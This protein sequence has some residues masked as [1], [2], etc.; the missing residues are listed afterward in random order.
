MRGVICR[1][2]ICD[3][4][5]AVS[6]ESYME[7]LAITQ[8][9]PEAT[10]KL[11]DITD[12]YIE[13]N[14]F[15][16]GFNLMIKKSTGDDVDISYITSAKGK[17]HC[18][19]TNFHACL[20]VSVEPQ[21]H[22]FKDMEA[23]NVCA[24]CKHELTEDTGRDADHINFFADIVDDFV[25]MQPGCTDLSSFK[26]PTKTEECKDGTHR[27][28]LTSVDYELETACKSYHSNV[29]K[30]QLT[31]KKCNKKRGGPKPKAGSKCTA[32]N[33]GSKPMKRKATS[34]LLS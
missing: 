12:F 21:I 3:S 16:G 9:H 31:C 26:Y 13:K 17:G 2:G 18:P 23:T 33:D 32:Q 24:I 20:R 1:I 29:A 15:G 11:Q 6:E 14:T 27:Y 10:A 4:V 5:R 8:N 25:L 30:L 28:R 7:V 22:K 19:R 34:M